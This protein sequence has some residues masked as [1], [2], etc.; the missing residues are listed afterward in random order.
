MNCTGCV[1][2]NSKPTGTPQCVLDYTPHS[3]IRR[4]EV[5]GASEGRRMMSVLAAQA[6]SK[7]H[8]SSRARIPNSHTRCT[9]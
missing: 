4:E 1:N 3:F 8:S 6:G 2:S 7:L 9:E 5:G